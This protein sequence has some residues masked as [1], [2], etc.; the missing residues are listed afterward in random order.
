MKDKNTDSQSLEKVWV[1][2]DI[3][4]I[5]VSNRPFAKNVIKELN[6]QFEKAKKDGWED[7]TIVTEE[8]SGDADNLPSSSII[9]CGYRLET[10][11]EW[12]RRLDDKRMHLIKTI[13][14]AQ[15]I[16]N[17]SDKIKEKIAEFDKAISKSSLKCIDCGNPCYYTTS[18]G[19]GKSVR[20]CFVCLSK[21]D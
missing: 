2:K 13:S 9:L 21:K 17:R 5:G 16:V 7:I 4:E 12:H 18:M 15:D 19:G 11:E 10:E 14:N 8:D 20:R 6:K 1:S 3:Y